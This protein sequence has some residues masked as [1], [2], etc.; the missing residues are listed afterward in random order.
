[1]GRELVPETLVNLHILK[2]LSARENFAVVNCSKTHVSRN[3]SVL[4]TSVS[5]AT[6]MSAEMDPTRGDR[7]ALRSLC[8]YLRVAWLIAG[9]SFAESNRGERFKTYTPTTGKVRNS[10]FVENRMNK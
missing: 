1:M 8:F 2:R 6:N 5:V 10:V 9:E 4:I 7:R 3:W